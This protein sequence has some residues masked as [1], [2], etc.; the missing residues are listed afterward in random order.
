MNIYSLIIS[1]ISVLIG[2]ILSVNAYS[3]FGKTGV[4]VLTGLNILL[5]FILYYYNNLTN[6]NNS[7]IVKS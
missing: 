2:P 4:V 7:T 1:I 3:H 6:N 5:Y